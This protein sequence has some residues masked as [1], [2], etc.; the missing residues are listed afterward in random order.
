MSDNLSVH[1]TVSL[2]WVNMCRITLADKEAT[3]MLN[4]HRQWSE[5]T[6]MNIL[7]AALIVLWPNLKA[8]HDNPANHNDLESNNTGTK[9]CHV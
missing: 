2:H 7:E 5:K 6:G 3:A 1:L 4:C 8:L 9:D